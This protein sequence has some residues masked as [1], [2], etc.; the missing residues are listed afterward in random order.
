MSH[1]PTYPSP[2][3]AGIVFFV[4]P[5]GSPRVSYLRWALWDGHGVCLLFL[6]RKRDAGGGSSHI[7]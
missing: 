4:R 5:G 6:M 7:L 3:C 2:A 1:L